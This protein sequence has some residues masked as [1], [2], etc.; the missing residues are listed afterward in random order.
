V[1]P[2]FQAVIFDFDGVIADTEWLHSDTFR[3]VL[4]EEEIFITDEDHDA[5]FL[6]IN[7]RAAFAK[8]FAEVSRS[9]TP[10]AVELLVARKSIYYAEKID[11]IPPY[12]GVKSLV[13]ALSAHGLPLAIASGGRRSEIDAILKLHGLGGH[14]RAVC[15]SDE[16]PRSKPAPD[17][18]LA[19]LEALSKTHGSLDAGR[20]V[21]IEDSVNGVRA[22]KA[23]GLYCVA[24]E[25]SF[26]REKLFEADRVVERIADLELA[27]FL[28][29]P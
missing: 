12:P 11:A 2:L 22:A 25:H 24:V 3:Q 7:D 17:L 6:G 23:A 28:R 8:A 26:P 27:D 5:R 16:V 18:F 29:K 14:F 15:S 9:I 21:A 10:G 13:E 1:S 4:A 20:C 19:A